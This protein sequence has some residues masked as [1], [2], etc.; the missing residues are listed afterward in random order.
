MTV[1][2]FEDACSECNETIDDEIIVEENSNDSL[3]DV[4]G[5]EMERGQTSELDEDL[6]FDCNESGGKSLY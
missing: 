3:E 6:L 1:I 5:D 2:I 4:P